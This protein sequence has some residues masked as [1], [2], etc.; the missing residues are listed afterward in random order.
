MLL[1]NLEL[2]FDRQ[3]DKKYIFKNSKGIEIALDINLFDDFQGQAKDIF[4]A[5]DFLPMVF[6]EEDRKNL[7]N[8]IL[9]NQDTK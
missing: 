2:S 5:M 7:L 6:A 9:N 1:N 8:D 3:E 4:L